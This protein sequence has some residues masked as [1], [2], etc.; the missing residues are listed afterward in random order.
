MS[1]LLTKIAENELKIEDLTSKFKEAKVALKE[2]V[3][4]DLEKTSMLSYYCAMVWRLQ[5]MRKSDKAT[6]FTKAFVNLKHADG[7]AVFTF[8]KSK[9]GKL[10][11]NR[12]EKLREVALSENVTMQFSKASTLKD[13]SSFFA[14]EGIKT[15]NGVKA[16]ACPKPAKSLMERAWALVEKMAEMEDHTELDGFISQMKMTYDLIDV[17]DAKRK[18]SS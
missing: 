15:S 9:Q 5:N 16:W 1:Q 17:Q 10:R 11:C 3:E 12:L 6:V 8:Y 7:S 13:I 4:H 2:G 14:D 18:F